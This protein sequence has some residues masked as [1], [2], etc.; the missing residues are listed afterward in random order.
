MRVIWV[1]PQR[2]N[3]VLTG[4]RVL[5][6]RAQAPRALHGQS[7][8]LGTDDLNATISGLQPYTT[9]EIKIQAFTIEGGNVGLGKNVTTEESG[10][11][12]SSYC[13]VPRAI[14]YVKKPFMKKRLPCQFS[15]LYHLNRNYHRRQSY[16]AAEMK[17]YM[18]FYCLSAPSN[19]FI[20]PLGSVLFLQS[21][22]RSLHGCFRSC[23]FLI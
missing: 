5:S 8:L 18:D 4:Y 14:F 9:Y 16:S 6:Y 21:K 3:G 12:R 20:C 11:E 7:D 15:L 10:I 17:I 2:P 1:P 13:L 23:S 19:F 22:W